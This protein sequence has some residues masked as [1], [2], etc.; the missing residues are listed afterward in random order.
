[1]DVEK[2]IWLIMA[3][4]LLAAICSIVFSKAR[5]LQQ[6][7]AIIFS[8]A[9]LIFAI[10]LYGNQAEFVYQ[11]A[12][13]SF[14]L[15]FAIRL[16]S[17]SSFILI[18]AA[19]FALLIAL[20][21]NAF[22][23]IE[24]SKMALF[25][26]Y[27]FITLLMTNGVALANN[28][29]LLLFFWEGLLFTLYAMIAI[30][31]PGSWK[32]A[33]KAVI[34]VGLCD[35]ALM[36][37]IGLVWHKTGTFT[38]SQMKV[39]MDTV[40]TIAFFLMVLG[41]TAKAGAI[42]FHTWIPDA[43]EDAPLPFMA[44]VPAALEK[45]I[46]IYFLARITL[47][48]FVL[49]PGSIPMQIL[50]Y[51]GV[52]TILIAV[53]M[54]LIQ[55]DYKRLLAYHA[56]SQVGYMILGIGTAVPAGIVGGIF[57]M[58][59]HA[60]YKSCLFLTGGS[61]ERQCGTTSLEKL[62]GLFRKMP[63]TAVC[64]IVAA[65]AISGVPPFNGFFSK[66][67]VYDGALEA[68]KIFYIGALL[69]SVLTAA[70]FLKLG[71][72]AYFGA[73]QPQNQNVKEAPASMLIPMITLAGLCT[74]FG[75]WNALPLRALVQPAIGEKVLEGHDFSG[76]PHNII[77]IVLSLMALALA[78]LNH[79][80]GVKR[81]GGKA[82]GASDHIHYAPVLRTIYDLAERRFFDLYDVGLKFLGV[83]AL[84]LNFFDRFINWLSDGFGVG[85]AMFVSRW[86]SA[87]HSGSY[88]KYLVWL[89]AGAAIIIWFI[90][91][92]K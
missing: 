2:I 6:L 43:A 85:V 24:P 81:A 74:L 31:R 5:L 26:F 14:G 27:L 60:M 59:N 79:I 78:I 69:G 88:P 13:R 12:G 72:S 52:A 16:Y 18:G 57:H 45:L 19:G 54:A 9:S 33:V 37:G 41:A 86:L 58:I 47:D 67:L 53:M 36:F 1:M 62:G 89:I 7:F 42:P 35:I 21:G 61:V 40:G 46:G 28:L 29:V 34:L 48:I 11:W 65:C 83:L 39:P 10:K 64:F 66:E 32:T 82:V 51:L 91:K 90:L 92:D 4:P 84:I 70:S 44:L 49:T 25:N 20:Y 71:H 15:D 80:F 8:A 30:G 22:F 76:L 63:I 73:L 50:M 23:C 3:I 87:R 68:G 75:L 77:L 55:K 17:F 38:I 56:V